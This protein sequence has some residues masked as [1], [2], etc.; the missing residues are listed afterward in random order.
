[1]RVLGL[2]FTSAPTRR[3]PIT[4]LACTF[5]G[6][7]LRAEQLNPLVTFEDFERALQSQGPWIAGVD[8]P[9][10]QARKFI[11]NVGWPRTWAG[12]VAH[13]QKLGRHGFCDALSSYR[14]SRPYGDKE[15]KR[16][17]DETQGSISPQKLYGVPVGL[18]FFEGA[19]RLLAAGVTIPYLHAGDSSRIVIEA[20]PGALARQLIGRRGYKSDTR[21]KQSESQREARLAILAEITSDVF[22]DAFG[23]VVE[24]Q[25]ELAGDPS[26]D[27]LDALLCAIQATW[28]WNRRDERYGAPATVDPLEGWIP[29]LTI[30][31][32]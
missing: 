13:A 1:M 2:D 16:K 25:T 24:A 11:E 31:T 18:M 32:M 7:A 23:F 6:G 17:T 15:H 30:T 20:Y 3:K 9:F 26:G 14:A 29:N 4:C 12:Y 28:A 5:D 22:E 19:S 10:G 27:Q 21:K 8:F